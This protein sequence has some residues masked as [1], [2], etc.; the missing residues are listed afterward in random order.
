[1]ATETFIK[2]G[3]I[4]GE[5]TDDKHKDEI[6]VLTWSWGVSTTLIHSGSGSG[7]SAGRAS[8]AD[9]SFTHPLDRASPALIKA[10][11][12]GEHIPD[13]TLA[14]RKSGEGQR[15]YLIIKMTNVIV[16]S[17]SP[18]DNGPAG[19]AVEAVSLQFSKVEYSYSGQRPDGSADSPTE[20]KFDIGSNHV[21]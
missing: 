16:T 17:V 2:I 8:F 12:L 7:A 5:S 9:L 6:E 10:C 4:K 13:A 3:A 21:F 19:A 1:M 15:D 14:A 20:F 18:S 11:A